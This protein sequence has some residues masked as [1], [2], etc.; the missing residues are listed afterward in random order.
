MDVQPV[1]VSALAHAVRAKATT[2]AAISLTEPARELDTALKGSRIVCAL[3]GNPP[4]QTGIL[5]QVDQLIASIATALC[6]IG[7]RISLPCHDPI[8]VDPNDSAVSHQGR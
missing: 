5:T 3:T 6:T 7:H 1:D 8:P 4:T 2:L